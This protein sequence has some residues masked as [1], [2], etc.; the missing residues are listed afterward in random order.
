MNIT[1]KKYQP[2]DFKAFDH[3]MIELMDFIVSIDQLKRVRRSPDYSPKYAKIVI[4]K[5]KKYDGAI[6][7]ACDGKKVVGCIAGIIEKQSKKDLLEWVPTK[8]GRIL[9]LYIAA[10]Y[11]NHGIGKMLMGKMETYFRNKKCD[12]VR[13]D[14]FSPNKTAFIFYEGLHYQERMRDMIKLLN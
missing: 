14:I 12:L 2:S 10:S 3:C 11:R 1:L 7:L 4:S 6:F 13:V 5:V 9:E 8:A